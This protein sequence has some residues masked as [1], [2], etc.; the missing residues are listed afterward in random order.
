MTGCQDTILPSQRL[1][2][3][4]KALGVDPLHVVELEAKRPLIGAN[5]EIL[6]REILYRGL[7]VV[8]FKRECIEALKKR[9]KEA[10]AR[11]IKTPP[12]CADPTGEPAVGGEK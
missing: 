6:K 10:S 7:S 11:S 1:P 3:L 4:I 5:A 8:I 9:K 2:I 12:S